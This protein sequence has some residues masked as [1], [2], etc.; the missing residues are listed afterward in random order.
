VAMATVK[1][2]CA[3]CSK[4][5][6]ILKCGGCI[7]DFCYNHFGDHRQQLNQ[8]LEEVEVNRD[9]FRQ[10]IT[11]QTAESQRHPLIN[12]VDQWERDSIIKIQQTAEEARQ[13]LL[14]HT[15]EHVKQIEVKL[16]QLTDQLRQGRE[17]NDFV[18]TDIRRWNQQLTQLTNELNKPSNILLRHDSKPFV[19][20]LYVDIATRKCVCC[21]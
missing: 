16:K 20:K 3:I 13:I 2:R 18:E 4:E 11:E 21:S 10:T 15:T 12:Q 5:K 9:L 14:Q 6:A 1:S 7:Q 19:T 8:Q 17:E